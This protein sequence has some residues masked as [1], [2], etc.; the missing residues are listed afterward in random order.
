MLPLTEATL[1]KY[2]VYLAKQKLKHQTIKVY[3][4]AL[5]HLQISQG[6]GDPFLPGAFPR[7]EYIL[8]GIKH[9]PAA[10]SKDTRLLI[11][12]AILRRL[13]G[14]WSPQAHDP[15]V[16]L[17]W[18]ACCLGFFGFMRAGEFT[19]P[20]SSHFDPESC[21]LVSDVAVDQHANPSL[22]RV[23]LKQSKTDPFRVGV[24]IFMG[25]TYN[26]LCPVSAVLAY[27]AVRPQ[28]PGPLFVFED[29]TYLTKERLVTHLR[30]GLQ[31]IGIDPGCFSGHSFRIGAATTAAQAGVE[32]ATVKIAGALGVSSISTL[33][34]YPRDQLAA[35]SA[36]LAQVS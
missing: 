8:K 31:E 35:I 33:Y 20:A 29:R 23:T 11:T 15:D 22:L 17:M 28:R 32:D 12:P 25:R 30:K 34:T 13:H 2:V 5:R 3:L 14:L 24:A 7:L 27:L 18:A 16:M 19:S 26:V 6:Q 21:L 9:M 36:R 1:S 10:Q 4:S